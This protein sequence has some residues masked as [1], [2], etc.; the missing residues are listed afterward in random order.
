MFWAPA[1]QMLKPIVDHKQ[2]LPVH[3][4]CR[5]KLK[6]YI[7]T[8][9]AWEKMWRKSK[10]RWRMRELLCHQGDKHSIT[11]CGRPNYH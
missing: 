8:Q 4:V 1:R 10:K 7:S 6:K 11:S 3:A 9:R 5:E 2:K